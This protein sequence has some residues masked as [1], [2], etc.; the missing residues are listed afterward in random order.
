MI[1]QHQEQQIFDVSSDEVFL[2]LEAL[3]AERSAYFK[4]YFQCQQRGDEVGEKGSLELVKKYDE[5][6]RRFVRSI[7]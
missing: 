1:K 4:Q 6:L 2:I 3:K 5:L 7:R